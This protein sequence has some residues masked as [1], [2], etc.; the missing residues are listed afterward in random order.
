MSLDQ[1]W[2]LSYNSKTVDLLRNSKYAIPLIQSVHLLGITMLLGSLVI[3]NLRLLGLGL[4]EFSMKT[5]VNQVWRWGVWG[6]GI[7]IASGLLV[8]LPDPTRYAA[9]T[10]FRVK[11]VLLCTAILYQFF[12]FRRVVRS[13][14][15]E[16]AS[17]G[18]AIAACFAL[19]LWFMVG[20][21]GRAIGFLG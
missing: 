11:L 13:E 5:L 10:A 18:N 2:Q 6:M 7:A 12:V 4:R 14:A 17:T 19:T 8:F 9:N 16:V 3:L 20:W 1:L 15:A 21:A